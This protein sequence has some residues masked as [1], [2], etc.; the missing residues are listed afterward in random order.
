MY[1]NCTYLVIPK[2]PDV[3]SVAHPLEQLII[4]LAEQFVLQPSLHTTIHR[5]VQPEHAVE[6]SVIQEPVQVVAQPEEHASAQALEHV[7]SH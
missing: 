2:Q 4:Q 6:Q 3:Q 1:Q 7:L 5:L